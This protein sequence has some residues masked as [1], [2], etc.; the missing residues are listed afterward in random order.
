MADGPHFCSTTRH[1]VH[2]DMQ[3]SPGG[4]SDTYY[5]ESWTPQLV[6]SSF[7]AKVAWEDANNFITDM[8]GEHRQV[9][10]KLR[11]YNPEQ[12]P[13]FPNLYCVGV[14]LVRNLGVLTYDATANNA[15]EYEQCE[16]NCTF[17]AFLYDVKEDADVDS[18]SR[19]EL[20]RYVERRSKQVGQSLQANG[21]FEYVTAPHDAI[22]TP[23]S[24]HIPYK[25]VKH[26]WRY[27]PGPIEN[28]RD[29]ADAMYGKT[30]LTAFDVN[31]DLKNPAGGYNPG[32]LMYLGMDEDPVPSTPAG[33]RLFHITHNYAFFRYGWDSVYRPNMG[34]PPND[35]DT[36]RNRAT[37]AAPYQRGEFLNLY[38][39]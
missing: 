8:I 32:T 30:N 38:S 6:N 31:Y 2:Y 27:V 4:D 10:T 25:E 29:V 9:G 37:L 24:I 21:L 18:N 26:V 36:A 19:K 20:I 11:R 23:P 1:G 7:V 17:A 35:W 12:H 13:F 22:P 39:L 34:A 16:Y 5:K 14:E 15:V 28:L 33:N 3:R